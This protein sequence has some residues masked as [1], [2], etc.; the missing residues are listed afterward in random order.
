MC[1]ILFAYGYHARYYLILAA[2][3]DEF[4]DRP[5]LQAGFW[6][7]EPNVLAGKDLAGEGTWLGVTRQGRLAAVTNY[8]NPYAVKES[9][10]SRGLVVREYLCGMEEPA[11]YL[12]RLH[13]EREEYNGF[14]LLLLN[15]H[16][17]WYYSN[18]EGQARRVAP[19]V[20][21]LS[22]HLLNTPWP[23]V[24]EGKQAF[25]ELAHRREEALVDGLFDLLA[26]DRPAKDEDLPATGVSL[27]WER[28]LSPAFIRSED[29]GTRSSTVVLIGRHGRVMFCERT[30][31]KGGRQTADDVYYEFDLER[32]N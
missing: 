2:N 10:R 6:E 23:K 12:E 5:T 8:R 30:F 31:I 7:D 27:E 20:H 15:N 32:N 21:G 14:N 26:D 17:L 28:L 16:D 29:Y 19:G 11:L 4:Y 1:L 18:L 25:L 9:A 24:F 3:R 13:R 22:N